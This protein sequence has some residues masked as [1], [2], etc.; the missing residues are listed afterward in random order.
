M[1]KLLSV[2]QKHLLSCLDTDY[3][4]VMGFY[5]HTISTVISF[6][7]H[8]VSF[9]RLLTKYYG[10][11]GIHE[12][13]WW[14]KSQVSIKNL[15]KFPVDLSQNLLKTGISKKRRI[16][17][18]SQ[19]NGWRSD[20]RCHWIS[21]HDIYFFIRFLRYFIT[22]LFYLFLVKENTSTYCNVLFVV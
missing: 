15:S 10:F 20:H 12:V 19:I 5:Y 4:Q 7:I 8:L 9:K 2:F 3:S 11:K 18:R 14:G 21:V 16:F 1:I 13:K 17:L 6:D 22:F